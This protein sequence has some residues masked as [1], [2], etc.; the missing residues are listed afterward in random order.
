MMATVT[1]APVEYCHAWVTLSIALPGGGW[2]T[3]GSAI[4]TGL[5]H[6]SLWRISWLGPGGPAGGNAA[7]SITG[8]AIA[9]ATG[10]ARTWVAN[11]AAAAAAHAAD[12]AV[13]SD[14]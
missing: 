5:M 14:T 13:T 10:A 9:K 7:G 11:S 8:G 12:F 4:T 1:P 2:T 6:A 3:S